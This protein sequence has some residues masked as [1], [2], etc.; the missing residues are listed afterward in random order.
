MS[1][2]SILKEHPLSTMTDTSFIRIIG[3]RINVVNDAN[4]SV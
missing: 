2:R 3:Q 4:I 1:I